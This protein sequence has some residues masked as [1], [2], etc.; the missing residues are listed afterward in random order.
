VVSGPVR[1]AGDEIVTPQRLFKKVHEPGG[2]EQHREE[3]KIR[4]GSAFPDDAT[5]NGSA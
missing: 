3:I 5:N 4:I 2:G 1:V